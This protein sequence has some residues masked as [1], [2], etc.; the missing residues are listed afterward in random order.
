MTKKE[1]AV[2]VIIESLTNNS[3]DWVFNGF[4]ADNDI[5]GLSI[6]IANIPILNTVIHKGPP[7]SLNLFDK[8]NI[9]RAIKKCA[10]N[11]VVDNFDN[12]DNFNN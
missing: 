10:A 4:T 11:Q 6:W 9:W 12:F 3:G 1:Q 7:L 5:L 2:E 8:Y